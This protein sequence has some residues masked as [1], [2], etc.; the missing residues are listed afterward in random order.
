MTYYETQVELLI[1]SSK[2]TFKN[3]GFNSLTEYMKHRKLIRRWCF[4]Y[5]CRSMD[6]EQG[7]HYSKNKLR[8]MKYDL[9]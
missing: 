4:L 2:K 7:K 9:R 8:R 5:G 1:A 6:N 3:V